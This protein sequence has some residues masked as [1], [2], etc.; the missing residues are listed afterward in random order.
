MKDRY[1]CLMYHEIDD[2]VCSPY[3][4]PWNDFTEQMFWLKEKGYK[5][6][7]LRKGELDTSPG[8]KRILITFDDGHKSNIRA[9]QFLHNLGFCAVFYI[10]QEQSLTNT[11]YLSESEI[12]YISDLGHIIGVHDKNHMHWT[13]LSNIELIE[14]LNGVRLWL[15]RLTGQSIVTCSAPGGFIRHRE[16]LLIRKFVPELKYIRSSFNDYNLSFASDLSRQL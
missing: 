5:T 13:K 7:D 2:G 10:L 6:L 14:D 3:H 4:V 16:Y 15:E 8:G 11:A 1:A 12:Q 9:A